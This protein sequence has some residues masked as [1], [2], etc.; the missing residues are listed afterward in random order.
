[1]RLAVI[2]GQGAGLSAASRARRVDPSLEIVVLEKGDTISYVACALPY[3]VEGRVPSEA[4]LVIHT[5]DDF[6]RE[7]GIEVRT[8]TTVQEIRHARRE[9]LLSGGERLAYDRLV[10]ATGA[11]PDRTVFGSKPP[12]NAFHLHTL[13]DA[14]RLRGFLE[15]SRPRRAVVIGAGYIGLEIADV[16]RARGLDVTVLEASSHAFSDA[17]ILTSP[18]TCGTNSHAPASNC[19][20]RRR[21][22]ASKP[23]GSTTSPAI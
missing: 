15:T 3:Y 21:L 9:L 8:A 6:Q 17:L 10:I 20:W 14:R 2:G 22:E 4:D 5:A 1:M 19:G 11:R 7:R 16:L 12:M 18:R 23:A 13:E